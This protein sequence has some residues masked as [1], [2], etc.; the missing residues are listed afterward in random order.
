MKLGDGSY[1]GRRTQSQPRG[2]RPDRQ[3][4]YVDDH[5]SSQTHQAGD[6]ASQVP[7]KHDS[8]VGKCLIVGVDHGKGRKTVVD[9]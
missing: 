7:G 5:Q 3:D 4:N 2:V 1:H 8:L 6:Q 9:D